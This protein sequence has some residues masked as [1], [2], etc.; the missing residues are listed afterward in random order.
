MAK[1]YTL[2]KALFN[3]NQIQTPKSETLKTILNYSK[4]YEAKKTKQNLT[5]EF[6][7]N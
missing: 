5:I 6:I 2:K 1:C 3:S 7:L 4:I